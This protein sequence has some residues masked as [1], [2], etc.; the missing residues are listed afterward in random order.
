MMSNQPFRLPPAMSVGAYQTFQLS[1][2]H[3]QLV[4]AACEQVGCDAWENGWDSEFDEATEL[5]KT[6]AAYVRHGSGRTFRELR[7]EAG[8]TVFRFEPG[9]RCFR[10]HHTRPEIYS[11]RNGDWRQNL[12]LIRQHARPIDWVEHFGEHQQRVADQIE[13]G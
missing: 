11:V 9:Q 13:R 12:G 6:Q 5:G 10:D 4:K 8:L 2:P 3:D 7:T 1:A